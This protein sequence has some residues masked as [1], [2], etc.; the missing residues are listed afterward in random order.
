MVQKADMSLTIV[1]AVAEAAP[2]IRTGGLGDVAG[3][4][5]A[6]QAATGEARVVTF[7]PLHRAAR[8]RAEAD[9]IG[10]VDV[11]IPL[12]VPL[13]G[14]QHEGRVLRV[15][16]PGP[17]ELYAIDAPALF[18]RDGRLYD[19]GDNAWRFGFFSRAV[20]LAAEQVLGGPP[21]IFHAHDWM[22]ALVPIYLAV[23]ERERYPVARS[24]FTIHNLAFQGDFAKELMPQLDLDWSLF[25]VELLEFWDRLNLVKGAIAMADAVTTVSPSFAEEMLTPAFGQRLE[26]HLLAHSHKLSG[27][28]NGIDVDDW[29]PATDAALP[30]PYSAEELGGKADCRAALLRR[31]GL[32]AGPDDPV[33]GV[34]SRLTWQKGLDMVCEAAPHLVTLGARLVVLG[35]GDH[36]MEHDFRALADRFPGLVGV[37]IAFDDALARQ[38]IAGSD[39]LLM[40][41]RFEPCGLTQIQA[42]RY[43]TIPVAAATGGLRDTVIDTGDD[44]LL[45]GDGTGFR[46]E[47][48]TA[49][50][51][52]WATARAI[53]CRQRDPDGW[54]RLQRAV[55]TRDWSWGVSARQYLDLYASLLA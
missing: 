28:L 12:E 17:A 11:G 53:A 37:E 31:F 20:L 16:L 9:G 30:A 8:L 36:A 42:M 41:S 5:P 38:V 40:P 18:D 23:H 43:G 10:L 6:A 14:S 2:L 50:G 3:S 15:D 32:H 13:G 49:D 25:K 55:M 44:A 33:L 52:R 24:V 46:T 19:H 51:V 27:I 48:A 4:L 34:V 7:L 22:T 39:I 26:T 47:Y 21:D 45:A 1:H 35:T 29:D 54:Q